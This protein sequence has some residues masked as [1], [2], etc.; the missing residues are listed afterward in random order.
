MK[1]QEVRFIKS[2]PDYKD[3]PPP[4]LPEY[5]FVGRSNVGKSSLI[6]ALTNRKGLA[7]TSSAPGKT[8]LINHFLV[9]EAWYL[10]DLPG[11]GYAKRDKKRRAQFLEMLG[12]Y[13]ELRPN[14][15]AT[16][17]L[18]DGRHP[19]QENDLQTIEALGVKGIP[20]VLVFTKTDKRSKKQL[21][22]NLESYK[23]ELLQSWESLPPIFL[24]SATEG[25][26]MEDILQYI[27]EVNAYFDPSKIADAPPESSPEDASA[28][29]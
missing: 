5:A 22:E 4:E 23:Q 8:Q 27:G 18:I 1:I 15:M 25:K 17:L 26:G 24:T 20:F 14:L 12:D 16:F 10:V 9:D 28:E 13:L 2:S 19:P 7:K 3:A 21:Q 29:S 6:N 11:Y